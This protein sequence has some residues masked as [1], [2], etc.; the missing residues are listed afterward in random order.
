MQQFFFKDLIKHGAMGSNT[1]LSI[2]SLVNSHP[3][4][5]ATIPWRSS[6]KAQSRSGIL[7]YILILQSILEQICSGERLK[8]PLGT[9]CGTRKGVL[10]FQLH[11]C[12]RLCGMGEVCVW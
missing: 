10:R 12:L 1:G 4:H 9:M 8:R 2:T 5:R 11:Q 7:M 3:G 6:G